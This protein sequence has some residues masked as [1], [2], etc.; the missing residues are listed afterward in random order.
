MPKKQARFYARSALVL[1]ISGKSARLGHLAMEWDP[2]FL[3]ENLQYFGANQIRSR[4]KRVVEGSSLPELTGS[5]A[6]PHFFH[7]GLKRCRLE[8]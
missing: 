2:L 8:T 4:F 6:Q 7:S 5:T 1:M 3:L